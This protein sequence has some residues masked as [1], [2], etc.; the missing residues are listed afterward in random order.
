MHPIWRKW[1]RKV[2]LAATLL[3]WTKLIFSGRN[4]VAEV[5]EIGPLLDALEE[6]LARAKVLEVE[7]A[8]LEAEQQR[9]TRELRETR[10]EGDELMVRARNLLRSTFGRQSERL[11]EHE[12]RPHPRRY[13]RTSA[14]DG[15]K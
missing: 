13:R 9:I 6:R 8:R 7:R 5:P 12:M 2:A 1:M 15:A 10:A 14:K 11:V 3:T 4:Q